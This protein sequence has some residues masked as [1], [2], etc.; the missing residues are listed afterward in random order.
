[1]ENE[2]TS[3]LE[4]PNTL[5]DVD[6]WEILS[7]QLIRENIGKTSLLSIANE[8]ETGRNNGKDFGKVYHKDGIYEFARINGIDEKGLYQADITS[9]DGKITPVKFIIGGLSGILVADFIDESKFLFPK[10]PG[11]MR[12]IKTT[13]EHS[14]SAVDVLKSQEGNVVILNPI[15][16]TDNIGV[17]TPALI[18]GVGAFGYQTESY[19][20]GRITRKVNDFSLFGGV[21]V[22]EKNL[23]PNFFIDPLYT[24]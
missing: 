22:P 24:E 6:M 4:I 19:I 8:V 21:F 23:A 16:E 17:Y 14:Y 7:A 20:N 1:M 3:A 2:K 18:I 15:N 5:I 12:R 9:E 13:G 11:R 10:H